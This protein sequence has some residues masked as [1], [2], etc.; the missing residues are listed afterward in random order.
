MNKFKR[1]DVSNPFGSF[2]SSDNGDTSWMEQ[3]NAIF[4]DLPAP[5]HRGD[6]ASEGKLIQQEDGT[7]RYKRFILRRT[8]LDSPEDVTPEE[9]DDLG[10]ILSVLENVAFW[11]GDWVL[12][13][14][15][16]EELRIGRDLTPSEMGKLYDDV[17]DAFNMEQ[18]TL[19]NRASVCRSVEPSRRQDGLRYSHHVEVAVLEPSQQEILLQSAVDKKWSVRE[20]RKQVHQM[21]SQRQ[22]SSKTLNT[23]SDGT[24]LFK[25][26]PKIDTGFRQL[27]FQAISGNSQA[28]QQLEDKLREHKAWIAKVE[29]DLSNI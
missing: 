4:G 8:Y 24:E 1:D 23:N 2:D 28:K 12:H 17:A 3:D 18:K 26:V 20:L 25:A 19:R 7:F 14:L 9:I 27:Y 16:L 10:N 5:P 22:L 6:T 21:R 15:K 11:Q 29:N 13:Y